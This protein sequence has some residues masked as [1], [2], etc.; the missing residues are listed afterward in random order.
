[1]N[2]VRF[3]LCLGLL[4]TTRSSVSYAAFT[5]LG[6]TPYRSAADSPFN[7]SGLGTTFFLEDFEDDVLTPGLGFEVGYSA[8]VQP[9][10]GNSVDEDDGVVDGIDIGGHSVNAVSGGGCIGN[11]CVVEAQWTFN[12]PDLLSYP[13]AVGIVI[14]ASNGSPGKIIVAAVDGFAEFSIEGI[15]SSSSNASDD[16]FIGITNSSGIGWVYVQQFMRPHAGVPYFPPSFDHLQ[17]GK[18]IPEPSGIFLLTFLGPLFAHR[19]CSR[20]ILS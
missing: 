20:R 15:V 1:M 19:S 5:F 13:T 10:L 4:L 14:T 9:R 18:F 17:Y 16:L 6:P 2:V 12:P 3:L 11:N 7:L 8:S